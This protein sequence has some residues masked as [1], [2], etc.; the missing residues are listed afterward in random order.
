ML[1]LIKSIITSSIS[2]AEQ[3]RLNIYNILNKYD[4]SKH[5]HIKDAIYTYINLNDEK[6]LNSRESIILEIYI[7]KMIQ[8]IN[9]KNK[10][11]FV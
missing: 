5:V 8:E 1:S 4:L 7:E 10:D 9:N 11:K 2:Q 6:I 3:K